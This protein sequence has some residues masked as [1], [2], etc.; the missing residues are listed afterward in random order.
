M[1]KTGDNLFII[2]AIAK[3]CKPAISTPISA[4]LINP[5]I[6][7]ERISSAVKSSPFVAELIKALPPSKADIVGAECAAPAIKDDN[8]GNC[9]IASL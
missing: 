4:P 9:V 2:G 7:R 8:F 1:P 3:A 6:V 5:S